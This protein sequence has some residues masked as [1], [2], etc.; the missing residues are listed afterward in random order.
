MM[1]GQ[2]L[3]RP[4][5]ELKHSS[6]RM[7]VVAADAERIQ[8]TLAKFSAARG[9]TYE[10]RYQ[11]PGLLE[12]SLAGVDFQLTVR[13]RSVPAD[14]SGT[15][16][17]PAEGAEQ[18]E[19]V[20][21]S[22]TS[23]R[24]PIDDV[25]D[26]VVQSLRGATAYSEAELDQIVESMPLLYRYAKSDAAWNSWALVFRDHYVEN[27][28]GF[29]LACERAG[30]A[31]EWIYALS[32]GDRTSH[33]DRVHATF[34]E[35]GYRSAVLDNSVI[36]GAAG[37]SEQREALLVGADVNEFIKSAHD[38]GRRVLVVDDGGLIAQGRATESTGWERIDGAIELTVSGLQRISRTDVEV[39]IFNMARSRLKTHI[40]YAEIADSCLRRVRSLLHGQKLLG[41]RIVCLGF[42]TLGARVARGL[43]ASGG[44][45]LVVDTDSL[46]LISAAE[47]GFETAR[48]LGAALEREAPFLITGSTGA[49]ALTAEDLPL[50]PQNV[51]LA[52]F[53]TKDFALFS[54]NSEN[55]SS[56]KISDIGTEYL[57]SGGRKAILLGDG[58]SLNLYEAEGIPN[59]GYDAYRAGT[60]LAAVSMCRSVEDLQPGVHVQAA[61]Q[62]IEDAGLFDAYYDTYIDVA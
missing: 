6:F 7:V 5:P 3:T 2:A 20:I 60:Y 54:R 24:A 29:L 10:G 28:V 12:G 53:A 43:R 47:E 15:L 34:I 59:Q 56:R 55:L 38:A 42:G 26:D 23:G 27:S 46:A 13:T 35:R 51:F 16:A 50:L 49:Q 48:T 37:E 8:R 62:A 11:V 58:R 4:R 14:G 36:D 33:R 57:L 25:L 31:P 22:T 40:A 45:V 41:R 39:P 18:C 52:G 19:V 44:R 9:Y 30:L 32:K 17:L 1:P 21:M 61:D